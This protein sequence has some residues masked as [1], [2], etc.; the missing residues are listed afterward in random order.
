MCHQH[1]QSLC[2]S[3][4]YSM[5]VKLLKSHALAHFIEKYIKHLYFS[6]NLS[7]Y[8][9]SYFRYYAAFPALH[10][11]KG[12]PSLSPSAG[13][14]DSVW[15]NYNPLVKPTSGED[16]PENSTALP[17]DTPSSVKTTKPSNQPIAKSNSK[18]KDGSNERQRYPSRS[19]QARSNKSKKDK[20]RPK[21]RY[22]TE[23]RL[24]SWPPPAEL[25]ELDPFLIP[26]NFEEYL[27]ESKPAKRENDDL[28]TKVES[29]LK[30][31][32]LP[33]PNKAYKDLEDVE[34]EEPKEQFERTCKNPS[35]SSSL[36]LTREDSLSP[37]HQEQD[38]WYTQPIDIIF[39][40]Q[41][42]SYVSTKPRLY[43]RTSQP[44]S[45][46]E[47]GRDDSNSTSSSPICN[48][49]RSDSTTSDNSDDI[50]AGSVLIPAW[51]TDELSIDHDEVLSGTAAFSSSLMSS[52]PNEEVLSS[53]VKK[54]S[55]NE[56]QD[57]SVCW[58]LSSSIQS[59]TGEHMRIWSSNDDAEEYLTPTPTQD[60]L[61]LSQQQ[62]KETSQNLYWF[63]PATT[64]PVSLIDVNYLSNLT[65]FDIDSQCSSNGMM[66]RTACLSSLWQSQ[67]LFDVSLYS[68]EHTDR[69]LNNLETSRGIWQFDK[70]Y[71]G[72]ELAKLWNVNIQ[73]RSTCKGP[74]WGSDFDKDLHVWVGE[75]SF[76]MNDSSWNTCRIEEAMKEQCITEF[77]NTLIPEIFIEIF[78]QDNTDDDVF[79][80]TEAR[81][82]KPAY[83]RSYS[84]N[85]VPSMW[86]SDSEKTVDPELSKS[87]E[88]V[89]SE[90]SA[91]DDVPRKLHHVLSEPNLAKY[92]KEKETGQPSPKEHLFFSPKT[93]FRPITPA[94]APEVCSKT[95]QQICND[96]FGGITSSKT[97]YQQYVTDPTSDD[98]SFVPKFKVKNYNKYIQ[99]GD[100]VDTAGVTSSPAETTK[101]LVEHTPSES[102][103]I[104]MIE[105]IV[106]D[107][108]TTD[109]YLIRI[110]E[111]LDAA[112]NDSAYETD[113]GLS[114]VETEQE[115][116]NYSSCNHGHTFKEPLQ[117]DCTEAEIDHGNLGEKLDYGIASLAATFPHFQDWP[118]LLKFYQNHT[119][120]DDLNK[121]DTEKPLATSWHEP[122]YYD[123]D[124]WLQSLDYNEAMYILDNQSNGASDCHAV[125]S[126]GHE[127]QQFSP[128]KYKGIW[129]TGQ[130]SFSSETRTEDMSSE[131][132]LLAIGK[133]YE[134]SQIEDE[135]NQHIYE[136]FYG[137]YKQYIEGRIDPDPVLGSI[138]PDRGLET[139][140]EESFFSVK[141]VNKD[142]VR[143][144][145][146]GDPSKECE[147]GTRVSCKI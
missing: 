39:Q 83:D 137:K 48:R 98:E 3:L 113:Y 40:S 61:I 75:N 129:S 21:R 11:N 35:P 114:A 31:M 70:E 139:P 80:E 127:D 5:I 58:S 33:A 9:F 117:V 79:E 108:E 100:G 36:T 60:L 8:S 109:D 51:L 52:S 64:A 17:A 68:T 144:R 63:S 126:C 20:E 44:D 37:E 89:P 115:K 14:Q 119:E 106:N 136:H 73:K 131:N 66:G 91:F 72:D 147:C 16:Q 120:T 140:Q 27:H 1:D 56:K 67:V 41:E 145:D 49:T 87:F 2:L 74:V 10:G 93:H 19:N 76:V 38:I 22:R 121:E 107:T 85:N 4:E 128:D 54:T 143:R 96:L 90:T 43:K 69:E 13:K 116:D 123:Q 82:V 47:S 102:L 122:S 142:K 133:L 97:P 125:W 92:R 55:A 84:M 104:G 26:D 62:S 24:Q 28:C 7:F 42:D 78:D 88:L 101:L 50:W 18:K 53:S 103:T 59:N 32:L 45:L 110:Y 65:S 34:Q 105:E 15:K 57:S 130:E 138:E 86:S 124:Q 71:M 132:D 99:T 77:E 25:L 134:E 146:S 95:K 118:E 141:L 30:G 81:N 12:S 111:D 135:E 46:T 112:N 94:F 23:D 29:I 6:A